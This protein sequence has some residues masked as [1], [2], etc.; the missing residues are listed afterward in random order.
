MDNQDPQPGEAAAGAEVEPSSTSPDP[1]ATDQ[2][3]DNASTATGETNEDQEPSTSLTSELLSETTTNPETEPAEPP[4]AGPQDETHKPEGESQPQENAPKSDPDAPSEAE[5]AKMTAPQ[6]GRIK[7]LL[8]ERAALRQERDTH[9][10][11]FERISTHLEGIPAEEV[12]AVLAQLGA[13]NRGDPAAKAALAQ[14]LGLTAPPAEKP[15]TEKAEI[16]PAVEEAALKLEEWG[17]HDAAKR[18]R[19]GAK[20]PEKAKEAPPAKPAEKPVYAPDHPAI[21][22]A[23]KDLRNVVEAVRAEYGA[24]SQ[25]IVDAMGQRFLVLAKDTEALTGHPVPPERFGVLMQR[26][27]EQVQR[28][29]STNRKPAPAG[30]RPAPHA[31]TKPA[32]PSLTDE[33]IAGR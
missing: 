8:T 5:L 27:R 16:P 21:A 7:N 25:P 31:S 22:S 30:G 17:E 6:R 3:G 20:P 9:A 15:A 14:R 19:E 28:E 32:V 4:A 26:A 13:A 29:L 1:V 24:Q 33:L 2:P 10:K 12:N 11:A 23:A 18:L